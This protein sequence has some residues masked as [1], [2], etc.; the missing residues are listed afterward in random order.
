MDIDLK[1]K[2]IINRS[3]E[4]LTW[5]NL[6]SCSLANWASLLK[7]VSKAHSSPKMASRSFSRLSSRLMS[8]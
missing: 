8:E 1:G 6:S 5:A 7:L 3:E 4:N 2:E